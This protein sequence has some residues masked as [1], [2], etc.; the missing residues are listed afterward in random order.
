[1]W[2]TRLDIYVSMVGPLSRC[3][4][5]RWR[6]MTTAINALCVTEHADRPETATFEGLQQA[7]V[8][9]TLICP[10]AAERRALLQAAGIR[11]LD[12]PLRRRFDRAGV[13]ALR[14][15][16][17][18]GRYDILHCSATRP[19]RAASPRAAACP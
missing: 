13:A 7:G 6:D 11:V 12:L 9:V 1:M 2:R 15:E 3:S 14:E 4:G 5:Q 18:R 17:E 16:I 19:C 8:D 10:L